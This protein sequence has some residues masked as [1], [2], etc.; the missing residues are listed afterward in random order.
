MAI[1][2]K[3]LS[4]NAKSLFH[5][6]KPFQSKK[7]K[8]TQPSATKL[9]KKKEHALMSPSSSIKCRHVLLAVLDHMESQASVGSSPPPPLRV[10]VDG[11]FDSNQTEFERMSN[12][13]EIAIL[14]PT[15]DIGHTLLFCLR[16]IV[17]KR[18]DLIDCMTTE[19]GAAL[20]PR[21]IVAVLADW[22]SD[23][24]TNFSL[25]EPLRCITYGYG[26]EI[27]YTK[28]SYTQQQ[29]RH[30]TPTTFWTLGSI[31]EKIATML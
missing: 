7:K 28:P 19:D 22:S 24:A 20:S 3:K 15:N 4:A 30:A 10:F 11:E 14:A 18:P 6:K 8:H 16:V 27:D 2:K 12:R 26:R 13:G 31:R 5:H 1:E 9:V 23:Q 25:D 29:Q 21:E 17:D